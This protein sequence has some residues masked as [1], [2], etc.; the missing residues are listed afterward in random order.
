MFC[1]LAGIKLLW[2]VLKRSD[3]INPWLLLEVHYFP[4]SYFFKT[5]ILHQ[6]EVFSAKFDKCILIFFYI[7]IISCLSDVLVTLQGN[8]TLTIER[9]RC[10]YLVSSN[11]LQSV[12]SVSHSRCST[13]WKVALK[14]RKHLR[15]VVL[16]KF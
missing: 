12:S 9:V 2:K 13:Y 5:I 10:V 6:T 11:T 16:M 7:C 4:P 14:I 15:K 1:E 3:V 8:Y